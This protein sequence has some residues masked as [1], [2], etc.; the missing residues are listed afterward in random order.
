MFTIS[1][2][3]SR[4]L[5]VAFLSGFLSMEEVPAFYAA[6]QE[7]ARKLGVRSGEHL[8]LIDA[9]HFVPQSQQV[10]AELKAMIST[11]ELQAER[12]AIVIEA[13]LPRMQMR[14]LVEDEKNVRIFET[15]READS[16]LSSAS[17]EQP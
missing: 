7:A 4:K 16:W 5:I 17:R 10:V 11:R 3:E 14:R 8:L 12:V 1:I 2:D 6:E 15:L 13:A 9:T